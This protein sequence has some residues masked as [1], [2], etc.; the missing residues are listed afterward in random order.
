[1]KFFLSKNRALLLRLFFTYPKRPYYIQEI[2]RILK[3]KPGVFQ[4]DL[5][6]L[7]KEG[8][9]KSFYKANARY[10][11]INKEYP[12]YKQLKEIISKTIG[13]EGSL[14]EALSK[15]EGIK[16]TFIFGSYAKEEERAISDIDLFII[17]NPDENKLIES[18]S[19][20]E[21]ELDREIN[22]H[23]YSE[24]DIEKKIKEKDSFIKSVIKGPKIMLIGKESELPRF[25]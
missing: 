16:S 21:K 12:L 9:L 22:Y 17:G 24:K 4:R 23:I 3:K 20:L 19:K 18:I 8:I 15:I 10:F 11:K 7:A 2:G 1:M 6:N 5:N 13:V 14:K 25:D